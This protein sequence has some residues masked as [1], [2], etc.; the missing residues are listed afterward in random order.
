MKAIIAIS[1]LLAGIAAY[2]A[3]TDT[4]ISAIDRTPSPQQAIDSTELLAGDIADDGTE[5]VLG[6][7][8]RKDRNCTVELKDYV[9]PDGEMFSAWSCTPH[10]QQPPHK[11]SYYDDATL[12][13]MAWSDAEAASTL[14]KRLIERDTGKSYELLVRATALDS[15]F[16]HLVWLADQAFGIVSVDGEPHMGNL[17]RQYELASVSHALGDLSG[18]SD[19]FR[20]ALVDAGADEKQLAGLDQQVSEVL[21]KIREIQSAVFGEVTIGG[22]DNA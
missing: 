3:V 16:R 18:R 5:I 22:Q 17:S 1:L 11:Y 12:E 10:S 4:T 6:L 19:Y 7:R 9:T 21:R 8:V 15:D 14:G 20:Q 13:V 2:L